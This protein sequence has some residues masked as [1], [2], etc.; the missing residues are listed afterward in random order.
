MSDLKLRGLSVRIRI[1]ES[2]K[3]AD[4]AVALIFADPITQD[5][6]QLVLCHKNLRDIVL[7]IL[8]AERISYDELSS[9]L[10]AN[11][12]ESS[13]LMLKEEVTDSQRMKVE[14]SEPI[15]DS[16][17]VNGLEQK[18]SDDAEQSGEV[19]GTEIGRKLAWPY[20]KVTF[21]NIEQNPPD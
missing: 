6:E 9:Q 7:T 18:I 8:A 11:T 14:E 10:D 12:A 17:Y 5:L 1:A 13:K 16:L 21:L 4:A 3:E 2:H 15:G 20:Q 19:S